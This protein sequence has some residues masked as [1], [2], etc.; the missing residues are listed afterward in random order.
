MRPVPPVLEGIGVR[1]GWSQVEAAAMSTGFPALNHYLGGG[2]PA[3]VFTE[4]RLGH[5]GI[6]EMRLL[7]PALSAMS[8]RSHVLWVA[9]PYRPYAPA[10]V[11]QDMVLDHLLLV[12]PRT[13]KEA[14]WTVGQ[15]LLSP[16]IG[17]V[18]SWFSGI[19]EGE[20]RGLQRRASEGGHWSFCFLPEGVPPQPSHLRLA[21]QS[22]RGALR[23]MVSQKAKRPL[24]PLIVTL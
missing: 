21:L 20:F 17:V 2:W 14:L 24:P 10:L 7:M 9:P 12:R 4:L 23:I 1:R 22:M 19:R 13:H 6:G 11:A 15:G 18:V 5:T 8:R 3:G 16:S